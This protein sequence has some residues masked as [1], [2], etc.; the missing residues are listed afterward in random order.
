M[1]VLLALLVAPRPLG[2]FAAGRSNVVPS[3]TSP[4]SALDETGGAPELTL[5]EFNQRALDRDGRTLL[6]HS[7]TLVGFVVQGEPLR[8][9]R[10]RVACCAAD[11]HAAM[12]R[13]SGATR[14]PAADRWVQVTGTFSGSVDDLPTLTVD[15]IDEISQPNDPYEAG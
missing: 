1:P 11:G 6:G 5:L 8:I 14:L 9:A 3:P 7:V 10:F 13:L 12:V 2:S 15:R 4:F